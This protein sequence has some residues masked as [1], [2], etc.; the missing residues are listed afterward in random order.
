[1]KSAIIFLFGL[2]F[3]AAWNWWLL[4]RAILLHANGN[5]RKF[6]R[7]VLAL[8]MF[9][10]FLC[11]VPIMRRLPMTSNGAQHFM[12]DFYALQVLGL[13]FGFT[14]LLLTGWNLCAR[15]KYR[16]SPRSLA[17]VCL[18]VTLLCAIT[19]YVQAGAPRLKRYDLSLPAVPPEADGYKIL[20]LS[21]LHLTHLYNTS[22][23]NTVS[24]TIGTEKPDIILHSGDFLD[25]SRHGDISSLLDIVGTWSAPDGKFAIFGNHDGYAGWRNSLAVHQQ[26]GFELLSARTQNQEAF[27]QPWLHLAGIDDSRIWM[28]PHFPVQTT[29]DD[30]FQ[31]RDAATLQCQGQVPR[32]FPSVCNLLLCHDPNMADGIPENY[33]VILSGHTHGGQLF[34]FNFVVFFT[35]KY[36]T[37][38][39]SALKNGG[40]IYICRGTGTWGPPFR[41]FI[42]PEMTLITLHHLSQ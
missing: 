14:G 9:F 25:S 7:V 10:V 29:D 22:V 24:Q 5:V 3:F 30:E 13:W 4:Q 38:K 33:D 35:C 23:L 36:P 6:G 28:K 18:G 20:L 17:C 11:I 19:G 2:L 34:P 39:W 37:S 41:L 40:R 27:P 32:T 21:D 26:A 1:M 12:R 16:L 15:P 31:D 42:P 8:L